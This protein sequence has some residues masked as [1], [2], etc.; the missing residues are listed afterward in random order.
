MDLHNVTIMIDYVIIIC[1]VCV[2]L[3]LLLKRRG[4]KEQQQIKTGEVQLE[5]NGSI[6]GDLPQIAPVIKV[7][8]STEN[9]ENEECVRELADM[10]I[11]ERLFFYTGKKTVYPDNPA[12]DRVFVEYDKVNFEILKVINI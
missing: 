12:D 10:Y 8:F 4:N 5:Q 2:F 7:I 9:E 3:Y 6:M 1:G 11:E